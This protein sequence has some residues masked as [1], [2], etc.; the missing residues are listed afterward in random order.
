M[1]YPKNSHSS[2][3]GNSNKSMIWNFL[4]ILNRKI[5]INRVHNFWTYQKQQSNSFRFWE[6]KLMLLWKC[7][8]DRV[9]ECE[10][11]DYI[12]STLI[13]F[14][15]D[16]LIKLTYHTLNFV[17]LSYVFFLNVFRLNNTTGWMELPIFKLWVFTSCA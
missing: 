11:F 15:K 17:T 2:I 12:T 8:D 14:Q 7:F 5:K 6:L 16:G 10:H 9:K 4:Q 13:V 1:T 3:S